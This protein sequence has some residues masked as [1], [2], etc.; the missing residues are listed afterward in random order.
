MKTQMK[1]SNSQIKSFIASLLVILFCG[2]L[3]LSPNL[4]SAEGSGKR[5]FKIGHCFLDKNEEI[6]RRMKE[7]T[8]C[9]EQK[10]NWCDGSTYLETAGKLAKVL[11]VIL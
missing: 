6:C 9:L 7:G 1:K 10:K 11:V 4:A 5:D 8:N 2:G 3:M